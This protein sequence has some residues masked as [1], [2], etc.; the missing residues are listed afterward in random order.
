MTEKELGKNKDKIT[1]IPVDELLPPEPNFSMNL[2]KLR[3]MN[4]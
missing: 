1:R 4:K 3:L 2:V